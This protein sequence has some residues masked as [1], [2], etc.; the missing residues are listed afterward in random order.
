M[1]MTAQRLR[2]LIGW[3]A[4]YLGAGVRMTHAAEDFSHLRVEMRLTWFN[5]NYVGTHFGGS[6][7]SMTDPH[8]MF[9]LMQRLGRDYIVW[10]Q[11]ANIRFV[12]PGRGT[13]HADFRV[14]EAE[15]EAI[16]EATAGGQPHRP[17]WTVEVRGADEAVV[18]VVV[19]TLYVRLKKRDPSV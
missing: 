5:R 10:D 3:Y 14:T 16:R 17:T 12:S 15:L 8:L 11:E 7:Y 4:P 2:W 18:A 6:L 19:K 13:V 1:K 9:M